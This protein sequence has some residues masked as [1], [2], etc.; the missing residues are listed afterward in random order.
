ML[1]CQFSSPE[2]GLSRTCLVK[3]VNNFPS[4]FSRME[5]EK[6]ARK[7]CSHSRASRYPCHREGKI[8]TNSA[9]FPFWCA[10]ARAGYGVVLIVEFRQDSGSGSRLLA[11]LRAGH[12]KRPPVGNGFRS[13]SFVLL[14]GKEVFRLTREILSEEF[15]GARAILAWE[16]MYS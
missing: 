10:I 12:N 11:C 3:I 14:P 8:L 9:V 15:K 1:S 4:P 6:L 16:L 2:C 13:V 5:R 7:Q